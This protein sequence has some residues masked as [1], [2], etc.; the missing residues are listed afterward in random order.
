MVA[1]M[2]GIGVGIDYALLLLSRYLDLVRHG[3][4]PVDAVAPEQPGD[5]DAGEDPLAIAAE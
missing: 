3:E 5:A 1:T 2:V 4:A